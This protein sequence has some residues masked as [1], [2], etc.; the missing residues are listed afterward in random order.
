MFEMGSRLPPTQCGPLLQYF[1]LCESLTRNETRTNLRQSRQR[2]RTARLRRREHRLSAYVML[3]TARHV[4]KSGIPSP[5]ARAITDARQQRVPE[6]ANEK[7]SIA[8]WP[9]MG[10]IPRTR[11]GRVHGERVTRI[12]CVGT[13]HYTKTVSTVLYKVGWGES[14]LSLAGPWAP[15]IYF[16]HYAVFFGTNNGNL[17]WHFGRSKT[18]HSISSSLSL[19]TGESPCA[20]QFTRHLRLSVHCEAVDLWSCFALTLEPPPTYI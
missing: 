16:P 11:N 8:P 10:T 2:S 18:R 7:L 14:T 12:I 19:I 15:I 6:G 20:N 3:V 4:G 5:S 9:T 17:L 1:G 13:M